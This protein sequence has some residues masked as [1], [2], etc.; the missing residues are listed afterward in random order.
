M[1]WRQS[2]KFLRNQVAGKGGKNSPANGQSLAEEDVLTIK[3]QRS[4]SVTLTNE[5][6]NRTL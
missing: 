5:L 1:I 6:I 2:K 3:G 4:V